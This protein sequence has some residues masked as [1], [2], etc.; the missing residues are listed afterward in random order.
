MLC[1]S[2]DIVVNNEEYEYFM[3]QENVITVFYSLRV[4]TQI[5]KLIHI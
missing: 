5:V 3:V 2:Y 1:K 4:N